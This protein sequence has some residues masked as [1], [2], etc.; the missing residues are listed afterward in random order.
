MGLRNQSTVPLDESMNNILHCAAL[1]RPTLQFDKIS[2]EALQ[3]QR[4]IQWFQEVE[5]V[6]RP[7]YREMV[8][9][10]G[11]K[12]RDLFAQEHR[13]LTTEG[14]KWIKEASQV[15][16]IVATLIATVMFAAAFTVPGGNDQNT[17]L[18]DAFEA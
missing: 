7:S 6:V 9:K 10:D 15:C 11:I 8:N 2:G 14:E 5:R 1:W 3:M 13:I 12:P 18:P 17:G 4:E 16:M